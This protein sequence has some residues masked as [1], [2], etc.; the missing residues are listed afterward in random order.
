MMAYCGS[1]ASTP[2]RSSAALMTIA[3]NSVACCFASPPP[4]FPKGVRTALTMT[5]RPAISG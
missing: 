2:I 1:C 3:P 5:L 4:S